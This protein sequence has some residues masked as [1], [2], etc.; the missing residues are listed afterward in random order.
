MAPG[1]LIVLGLDGVGL[2][3]ALDLAGQGVM[4]NLAGLLRRGEAW[5]TTSVL[6]EVS[7]VCWGSM[8]SG[9]NPGE[10]G[11]FGF[12]LPE[13]GEYRVRPVDAAGFKAP[14]IWERMSA[15]N[16]RSVV[17]NV[18]LTYPARP[19]VG[20]MVSGFVVVSLER[21]V[22]PPALLDKVREWGYQPEADMDRGI[23]DPQ[24]LIQDLKRVI[25]T[26]LNL[27]EQMLEEEWELF[28][29]V[30]T[31]TDRI[32]HFFYDALI[33][34][35]HPLRGAAH[36]L[37]RRIDDFIGRM[38]SRV[39]AQVNNGEVSLLLAADHSFGPIESEV[40]LNRWLVERGYL[41]VEGEP[42]RERILPGS[43]ALALDPG[44]IYLHTK[45]RF[46]FGHLAPGPETD[47]LLNQIVEE[48]LSLKLPDSGRAA[49]SAVHKK[50]AIYHGPYL[51]EAPDLV[52]Q[53]APGVSLRAGL[54]M[55]WVFGRSHLQGTHRPDGALALWLG[56]Q[57]AQ[58]P[59]KVQGLYDIMARTLHLN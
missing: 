2:E 57:P 19:I 3:Q 50:Q 52:A 12:G 9:V 41:K 54:G 27:F 49:V 47:A 24:A 32:N 23:K 33:A 18:P 26:R 53:A 44:R 5:S 22:Y 16:R 38:W 30:V 8:F 4:P 28:V 20:A 40:Y 21:A 6:P 56:P 58:K 46:P 29:A 31:D 48:M 55:P 1:R 42:G 43:L 11:V 15:M 39:S 35:S 59:A 13:P 25:E 17:L 10:H 36:D 7:P 45:E 34:P 51:D 14:R 37:F